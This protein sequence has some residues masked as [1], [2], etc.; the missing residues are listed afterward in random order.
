MIFFGQLRVYR[1][2]R[3][4]DKF[5]TRIAQ[6]LFCY[7][8]LR[9]QHCHSRNMLTGLFWRDSPEEQAR[10]RLRTTLW[11]VR[12]LL[13]ADNSE[14]AHLSIEND[15]ICFNTGSNYWLDVQEFET[16][17]SGLESGAFNM[18][19][20]RFDEATLRSLERAVELYRG[21]L[22]EGCYEDWSLFE[23][24]R[25]QGM[26]LSALAR[27]MDYHRRQ[28][29]YEAAIRCGLRV[30]SYDPLLE[31]VHREVMRLHCLVGNRGAAVRQYHLCQTV[32]E[33]ELGIGPMEETAALYAQICQGPEMSDPGQVV[34]HGPSASS[35]RELKP[36]PQKKHQP[37]GSHVDEALTELRL[38]Q[39]GLHHLSNR[40]Q[41][42]VHKIESIRQKL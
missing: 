8:V 7:L 1:G 28:G 26:F 23:R 6:H 22:L 30:L 36:G 41:R 42:V 25:L 4:L 27:L 38:T 5:P 12:S 35:A 32:L 24:E 16:S 9:R 21:D 37:L 29:A 15:D 2:D 11:R 13:G 40:F 33:K 10:R 31:E 39:A 20:E 18:K 3:L 34:D 19:S 14:E 17:L